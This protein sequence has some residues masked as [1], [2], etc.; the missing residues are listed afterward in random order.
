QPRQIEILVA[1]VVVISEDGRHADA[2]EHDAGGPRDVHE[3]H[4][5]LV[6]VQDRPR[7]AG[8]RRVGEDQIGL[9]VTVEVAYRQTGAVAGRAL[10]GASVLRRRG[11]ARL[12]SR[13][14]VAEG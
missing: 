11:A 3:G 12:S 8:C 9:A 1:V 10:P 4:A 14:G 7:L 6:P 13:T 5:S 2:L